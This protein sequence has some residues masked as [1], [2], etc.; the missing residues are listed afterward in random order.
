MTSPAPHLALPAS[1]LGRALACV[2]V[3]HANGLNRDEDGAVVVVLDDVELAEEGTQRPSLLFEI[4]SGPW[5]ANGRS[6]TGEG[7]ED[8]PDGDLIELAHAGEIGVCGTIDLDRTSLYPGEVDDLARQLHALEWLVCHVPAVLAVASF[9][10]RLGQT[11][12]LPDGAFLL[13]PTPKD[14]AR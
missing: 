5:D 10:R 4:W 6:A 2:F 13:H 12:S 7:V 1:T 9:R 11:T 14:P 3:P 8:G